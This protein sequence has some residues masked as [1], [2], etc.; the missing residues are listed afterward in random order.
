M[1]PT[2]AVRI[3]VPELGLEHEPIPAEDV[4]AGN[5]GSAVHELEGL[6]GCGVGIWEMT[7]G[8]ATDT[9]SEEVFVVLSG[10]ARIDFLDTGH[11]LDV[12]AGDVVRLRAGQ[13]TAWTV[14]QKLRKVYF[15][16]ER[17]AVIPDIDREACAASVP[18]AG[19]SGTPDR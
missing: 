7:P 4:L 5:P 9:E 8:A 13:R 18:H 6:D 14:T 10:K 16:S 11:S 2:A 3:S 17:Q 1:S 15:A 19:R 12:A